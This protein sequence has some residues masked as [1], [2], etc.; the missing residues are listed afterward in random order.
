MESRK[1]DEFCFCFGVNIDDDDTINELSKESRVF[2]RPVAKTL[3]QYLEKS[4]N[5]LSRLFEVVVVFKL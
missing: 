4:S 5:I 3:L 2:S 1:R